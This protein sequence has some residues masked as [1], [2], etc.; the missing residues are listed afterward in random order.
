MQAARA[1]GV[2]V[3]SEVELG[4]RLLPA[5]RAARRHHRHERQDDDHRAGRRDAA[6][7]AACRGAVAGNIGDALSAHR[8]RRAPARRHRG[9]RAVVASSSRTSRRL[10][11]DAAVAAQPDARPP[12]PARHAAR[13]TRRAKLRI[14]ERQ[15]AGG[16][17][18][19]ERRR[20]VGGGARRAVP[21]RARRVRARA[22]RRGGCA[23]AFGRSRL[24]RRP[25]PRERRGALRA[26]AR[27]IGAP[28]DASHPRRGRV[29]PVRPPARARRRDRRRRAVERLQGHQ[30]RRHAEGADGLR[31]HGVHIILGGSYK[32][33]DFAPLRGRLTGAVRR[34]VPDRRGRTPR[35]RRCL[36]AAGVAHASATRWRRPSTLPARRAA[37]R[38]DPARARVR[39]VRRVPRLR[40]ARRPP[41]AC[42]SSEELAPP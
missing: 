4:Y 33:A 15:R 31:G 30:R 10:R 34:V 18:G 5:G 14:F 29:P 3:W 7:A 9:V 20:P 19:A 11:C 41:S 32:G 35:W 36:G 26:L 6:S 39:V 17:G 40:G 2:P 28:D 1:A 8:R 37:G 12:R 27:A 24:A 13:P 42:A 25:Q 22:R 38:G 16:R 23:S 21:R